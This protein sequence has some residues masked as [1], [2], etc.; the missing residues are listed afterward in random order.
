MSKRLLII[1]LFSV[2]LTFNGFSQSNKYSLIVTQYQLNNT[3]ALMQDIYSYNFENGEFKGKEKILTVTGK[4]NA[5][6]L[7]RADVEGSFIFKNHWLITGIGNI[8]DLQTKQVVSGDKATF[9]KESGDSLIFYT[10]DIFKGKFYSVLDAKT[11]KYAEV[12]SAKFKAIVAQDIEV[13]YE[14]SNRS[15]WLYP[16]NKDKFLLVSDAGFG[17]EIINSKKK[18][19]IPIYWI[20]KDNFLFPYYN[21]SKNEATIFKVN[22]NKTQT[23]IGVIKDVPKSHLNSYFA[24]DGDGNIEYVCGKGKFYVDIKK[25]SITEVLFEHEGH[26]YDVEWKTQ[27]YGH[28]IKYNKTDIGKYQCEMKNIRTCKYAIAV[29]NKMKIGEEVY[30]QGIAV[31]NNITKKWKSIDADEVAAIAGWIVE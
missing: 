7:I 15:I 14:T 29:D 30:P 5:K 2:V 13:D 12:K 4:D 1:L 27:S 21:V 22:V 3:K 31:W 20:D 26:G 19:E 23:K 28:A 10:N 24:K 17:E 25:L 18:S 8:I 9:I 16:V 6:D 11:G